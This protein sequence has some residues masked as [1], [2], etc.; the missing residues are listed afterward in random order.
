M[1]QLLHFNDQY[2]NDVAL[3]S[4]GAINSGAYGI[5]AQ[6]DVMGSSY[7]VDWSRRDTMYYKYCYM[8]LYIYHRKDNPCCMF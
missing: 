2:E 7:M 8:P 3:L 6:A 4:S 5:V 1:N